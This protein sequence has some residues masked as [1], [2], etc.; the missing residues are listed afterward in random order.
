MEIPIWLKVLSIIP[1][2]G[3]CVLTLC[4]AGILFRK[5]QPRSRILLAGALVFAAA[6]IT[7]TI[8]LEINHNWYWQLRMIFHGL[9][10]LAATGALL[11]H[12]TLLLIALERRN[13][14]RRIAEL[15]AIL[16][17]RRNSHEVPVNSP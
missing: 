13:Q 3:L 15:E 6:G 5:R 12:I 10:L 16:Q 8:L 4:A 1:R 2:F 7:R 11:F 14:H 9:D 17:D